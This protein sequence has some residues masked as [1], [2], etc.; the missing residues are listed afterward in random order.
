M[1]NTTIA[2]LKDILVIVLGGL[3]GW[4]LGKLPPNW[5]YAVIAAA[6]IL[7]VIVI[8]GLV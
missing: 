4:S 8:N 3:F 2:L 1:D 7:I 5:I 6:I